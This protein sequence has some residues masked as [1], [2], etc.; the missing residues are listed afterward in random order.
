[1]I[2]NRELRVKLEQAALPV[3]KCL[4]FLL[5]TYFNV[6]TKELSLQKHYILQM[7]KLGIIKTVG[8]VYSVPSLFTTES[9]E[10]VSTY[11]VESDV[12]NNLDNYRKLF[13]GVNTR[14][15]MQGDKNECYKKLVRWLYNNP[16]YTMQDIINK[17]SQYINKKQSIGEELFIQ[18]ADYLV[19]KIVNSEEKSTLATI[20]DE[21]F[22]TISF[23]KQI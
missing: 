12:L 15:G 13:K 11:T 5:G 7:V 3:E 14:P 4:L 6:P 21:E 19:Y 22:E 2:I 20:I 18:Q 8:A 17:T 9:D 23:Q 16:E 1:M 10:V